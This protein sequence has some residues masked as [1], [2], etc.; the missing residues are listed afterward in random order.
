LPWPAAAVIALAALASGLCFA[1]V[2]KVLSGWH[3]LAVQAIVYA[4][5]AILVRPRQQSTTA[6]DGDDPVPELLPLALVGCI[7]GLCGGLL[8]LG[9]GLVMVPLMVAWLGLPM[10]LAIRL[11][12]VA[13]LLAS[14][15]AGSLFVLEGRGE[16][17]PALLLGGLA[18]VAAKWAASRLQ[19][20]SPRQLAW[21]LRLLSVA[22]AIDSSRRAL[23]LWLQ[24]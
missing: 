4:L 1:L 24:A 16:L 6:D 18:A 19:R 2:G 10:H 20:V 23:A 21:L 12:T 7:A 22:L 5:V 13:V 8:G 15:G 17:L 14:A 3:L 9:G 11:S